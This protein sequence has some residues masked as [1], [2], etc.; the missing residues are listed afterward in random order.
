MGRHY[1]G[2]RMNDRTQKL[3]GMHENDRIPLHRKDDLDKR[4]C[5]EPQTAHQCI[6]VDGH[7]EHVMPGAFPVHGHY[8]RPYPWQEMDCCE[9]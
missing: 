1:P 9:S 4:R 8:F 3:D 5:F 6:S 2:R 7:A